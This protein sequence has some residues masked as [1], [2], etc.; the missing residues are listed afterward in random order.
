MVV[1]WRCGISDDVLSV[2]DAELPPLGQGRLE[3]IVVAESAK[4]VLVNWLPFEL[5]DQLRRQIRSSRCR[6]LILSVRLDS[7]QA[8]LGFDHSVCWRLGDGF[9]HTCSHWALGLCGAY[10]RGSVW[11]LSFGR[12]SLVCGGASGLLRLL[13][14]ENG[15]IGEPTTL[16]HQG[17][18]VRRSI[19]RC[20]HWSRRSCAISTHQEV[21][22][23]NRGS[24]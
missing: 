14:G 7:I 23:L 9:S 18:P 12:P 19:R 1:D 22:I 4:L 10:P 6:W 8:L 3:V 15:I 17:L 13:L 24:F 11:L 16:L 20:A 2:Q 21:I 5:L